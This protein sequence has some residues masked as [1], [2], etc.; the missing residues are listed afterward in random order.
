MW[1]QSPQRPTPNFDDIPLMLQGMLEDRFQ[2]KY[3]W[4]TR[5][6]PGYDLVVTKPGKLRA[7]ILKAT[8]KTG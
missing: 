3:H 1:M 4:E 6:Q 2:L 7:S 5:E 8:K